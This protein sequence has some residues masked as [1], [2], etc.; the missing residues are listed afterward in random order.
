MA[1]VK[2]RPLN[3]LSS[4][5]RA[6][7]TQFG[8]LCWRK[9]GKDIEVLM[10]TSRRTRRWIIPKG[11][12]KNDATPVVSATAEAWEEAGVRGEML[13]ICLGIYSYTKDISSAKR[14]PCVVA[15]FPMRVTEMADDWPESDQR[16]RRWMSPKKAAGL[17]AEPELSA[18]MRHFNPKKL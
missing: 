9:K 3:L 12:P 1:Q 10:V 7:R 15:V 2:Q 17:V 4:G 11:W 5:K 13:P 14:L 6:V 16:K 18:I 8:A